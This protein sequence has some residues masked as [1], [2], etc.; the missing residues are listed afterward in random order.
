MDIFKAD[1]VGMPWSVR[2]L[3]SAESG[4]LAINM[5]VY[6]ELQSRSAARFLYRSACGG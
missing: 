1:P 5:M 6:A 4:Q 3:R 2:P